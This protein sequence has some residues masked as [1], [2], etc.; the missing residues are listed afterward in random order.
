M[1]TDKGSPQ[2]NR[3]YDSSESFPSALRTVAAMTHP[4]PTRIHPTAVI[5][6]EA[7]IAEDVV[8]GPFVVIEGPVEIDSGCVIR[9][10][11]HLIGPLRMGK[12]NQVFSSAILGD[13][14]QDMSYKG[15][16]TRLEIGNG[17]TFREHVTIHRGSGKSEHG[18]TR[19]GNEN[20]L[21]ASAHVGHDSIVGNH[22]IFAN[23]ALVG[24]HCTVHDGV[25]LS[26]HAAVH[27]FV[28]LGRLCLLQGLSGTSKDVPP[29][30]MHRNVNEVC[31]VNVIGMRRSGCSREEIEAVRKAFHLLYRNGNTLS[32]ALNEIE[33][34]AGELSVIQE[35]LSF[36][37]ESKRGVAR[38][39]ST[40]RQE[41]A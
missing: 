18:A 36:I 11:A 9:P 35:M 14:P 28:S 3:C 26:G 39:L 29:F 24:G 21:M 8:I 15:E 23:G 5:S 32:C 37:R 16:E 22:C 27:Q 33:T 2:L 34:E 31:G 41:A 19:I 13:Q 6:S 1:R 12:D 20:Y 17:N 30:I 7:K 4:A 38:H 40:S 10:Y 25:F